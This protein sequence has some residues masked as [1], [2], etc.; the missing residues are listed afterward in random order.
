MYVAQLT[1]TAQMPVDRDT[2]SHA[3]NSLLAAL[4][5]NGQVCGREWPIAITSEDYT[6]TVLIPEPTALEAVHHNHYA[7][8]SLDALHTAGLSAPEITIARDVDGAGTCNCAQSQSL[9][10][11]TYDVSLEP[12]LRCGDCFLPVPLY[13]VPPIKDVDYY[14]IICWQS[15]YQACDRLQ[16]NC[17]TLERPA[18]RQI[19]RVDSSLSQ[20]GL[21]ICRRLTETT[22][23][24]VY[25]YLYSDSARSRRQEQKRLCPSCG[26]EWLLAAPWH[27]FDFKC[28]RCRLLSTLS[29]NAR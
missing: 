14:E 19:S 17:T 2:A 3:I 20:F 10:L 11:Y 5:M 16:M 15:D 27:K 25:Y 12:P 21:D 9:I 7:T 29:W 8:Q 26:S 22:H 13:R 6:A 18:T 1:M 28:D 24:P 4:R 23:L